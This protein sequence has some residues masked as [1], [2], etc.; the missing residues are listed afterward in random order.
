MSC[1]KSVLVGF[2]SLLSLVI[3]ASPI[4]AVPIVNYIEDPLGVN[5][6]LTIFEPAF[7]TQAPPVPPQTG[8]FWLV[9]VNQLRETDG[10]AGVN[11]TLVISGNAQH[12]RGPVGDPHGLGSTFAFSFDTGPLN[13]GTLLPGPK[14]A[15]VQSMPFAHDGH[16]DEFQGTLAFTTAART[17][18]VA[19]ITSYSFAVTGVHVPE[20]IPEPTTLLLWG[21][22]MAGLGLTARW[23]QRRRPKQQ[24]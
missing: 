23:R 3:L 12:L 19:D 15:P 22:T 4:W 11:D 17:A 7:A 2:V 9:N 8:G 21:T 1:K 13:I 24:A 20:P 14:S 10:G 6:V 18:N 5:F 16:R